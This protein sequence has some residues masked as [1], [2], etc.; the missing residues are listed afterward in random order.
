MGRNKEVAVES[1]I[2]AINKSLVVRPPDVSKTVRSSSFSVK[3][4]LI[5]EENFRTEI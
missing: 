1:F 3:E 5:I 4:R 2:P